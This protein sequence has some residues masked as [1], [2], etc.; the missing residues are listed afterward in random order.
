MSGIRRQ[1][2]GL[3]LHP[4]TD[5]FIKVTDGAKLSPYYIKKR[6]GTTHL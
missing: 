3:E 6:N 5:A 2:Y 4:D 1:G